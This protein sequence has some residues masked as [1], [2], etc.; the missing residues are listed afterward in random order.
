MAMLLLSAVETIDVH[1]NSISKCECLGSDINHSKL[2]VITNCVKKGRN[3]DETQWKVA[4]LAT[5]N[6]AHYKGL[7]LNFGD[8]SSRGRHP[9]ITMLD[10]SKKSTEPVGGH[11]LVSMSN[12]R[13]HSC[14]KNGPSRESGNSYCK[15]CNLCV[16][17]CLKP[18]STCTNLSSHDKSKAIISSHRM[19]SGTRRCEGPCGG[20]LQ[21]PQCSNF[22]CSNCKNCALCSACNPYCCKNMSLLKLPIPQATCRYSVGDRVQICD[23]FKMN[24]GNGWCLGNVGSG[25]IG[26][27]QYACEPSSSGEEQR[28]II[29]SSFDNSDDCHYFR[30]SW[31]KLSPNAGGSIFQIGDRVQ[32]DRSTYIYDGEMA[33]KCLGNP[34]NFYFGIVSSVGPIRDSIQ[35]NIEVHLPDVFEC[36]ELNRVS[37]YSSYHLVKADRDVVLL[38]SEK[39]SLWQS[40]I[41]IL[42]NDT[43]FY[44]SLINKCG[45]KIWSTLSSYLTQSVVIEAMKLWQKSRDL[46]N[47]FDSSLMKTILDNSIKNSSIISGMESKE[48]HWECVVCKFPSNSMSKLK[49]VTPRCKGKQNLWKCLNC[50][51]ENKLKDMKC[52][53]CNENKDLVNLHAG[54]WKIPIL[55]N[56]NCHDLCRINK[57]SVD[58]ENMTSLPLD[59]FDIASGS[60]CL[61]DEDMCTVPHWSCCGGINE[62]ELICSNKF[63]LNTESPIVVDFTDIVSLIDESKVEFTSESNAKSTSEST[64]DTVNKTKNVDL[65]KYTVILCDFNDNGTHRVLNEPSLM[66]KVIKT[67]NKGD[68]IEINYDAAIDV[69]NSG[70][71][72][73]FVPLTDGTGWTRLK[74]SAGKIFLDKNF[75]GFEPSPGIALQNEKSNIKKIIKKTPTPSPFQHVFN[76]ENSKSKICL[77]CSKCTGYGDKCCFNGINIVGKKIQKCYIFF[78]IF[79]F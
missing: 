69:E 71:S 55:N 11:I 3:C 42:G 18:Q 49:C 27:V 13:C 37:L 5:G 56:Q 61:H 23:T 50:S 36:N 33:G 30:G 24:S 10:K 14:S 76:S 78:D 59:S 72:I 26:V 2:G 52:K 58:T 75:E 57:K 9:A 40:A 21:T 74:N 25:V 19:T 12:H 67:L 35:R 45:L 7:E 64:T 73:T 47:W 60:V 22:Y 77:N 17:C 4:S 8:G 63:N 41:N 31:L 34:D 43:S 79:L 53:L 46:T 65:K 62:N 51:V 32:I 15:A 68:I 44:S 29:V 20:S 16:V 6:F 38:D 1:A 28:N 54:K 39:S 48:T 66:G 70:N